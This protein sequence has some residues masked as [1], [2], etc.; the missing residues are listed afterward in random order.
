[1]KYFIEHEISDYK[2]EYNEQVKRSARRKNLYDSIYKNIS[3]RLK[4]SNQLSNFSRF[5]DKNDINNENLSQDIQNLLNY[6]ENINDDY[7]VDYK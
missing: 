5:F 6:L 7:Y 1:M 2:K 4:N 3:L